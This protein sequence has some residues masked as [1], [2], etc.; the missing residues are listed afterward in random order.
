ME[1]VPSSKWTN[2]SI[3]IFLI[4]KLSITYPYYFTYLSVFF[5]PNG[6]LIP[7]QFI[8][9]TFSIPLSLLIDVILQ[10]NSKISLFARGHVTDAVLVSISMQNFSES[11]EI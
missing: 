3:F 9:F 5:P 11:F 2:R 4:V 8:L 6:T 10:D 7:I 1:H